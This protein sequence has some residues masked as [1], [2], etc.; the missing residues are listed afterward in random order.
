MA[1]VV[2]SSDVSIHAPRE[3]SD[4]NG[5][6]PGSRGGCFNPRSPR[7]ERP[8]PVVHHGAFAMFQS[9]LPAK[10]ATNEGRPCRSHQLTF[11]STL[12][13][14]GATLEAGEYQAIVRF[15][16]TLPAKG[17]TSPVA[18]YLVLSRVSIH[19]PREGSDLT[20]WQTLLHRNSFN[21]RSPRRERPR[22]LLASLTRSEVS[23]HA[24]REGSDLA[25]LETEHKLGKFQSTLPAK[26][27]TRRR[28]Q[29]PH[30]SLVSIHAPREGSDRP[31]RAPQ[32]R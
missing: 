14:K 13:A 27:A 32:R 19:A 5:S 21:P 4:R 17:A 23:I 8:Y 10:G 20:P 24:P 9:T 12:P 18:T 11:Q 2:T 16:S 25:H 29:E 7:R 26:G 3:G 30:V 15:Q 1:A 22:A 31:A 6:S 28:Q